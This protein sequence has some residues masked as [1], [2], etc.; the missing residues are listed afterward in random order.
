MSIAPARSG[1]GRP[2]DPDLES[3][4]FA[5][6]LD[7]YAEVGWARFSLDIVARRARVGKAALYS[8]WGSK[9]KLI[10][11]ALAQRYEDKPHPDVK[12][13]SVRSE[14]IIMARLILDDLLAPDSLVVLRAMVEARVYPEVFGR[15]MERMGRRRTEVGR[16]IVLRAIARG[17]LPQGTSPALI[18]DAVGG[19]LTNHVLSTPA[20]K[21]PALADTRDTYTERIVDFVL[22]GA[23]Y[24][25]IDIDSRTTAPAIAPPRGD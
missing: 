14:L 4:V 20:D 17:E 1:P 3:R 24:R 7:L 6:T 11:A 13:G 25:P 8:R 9:E 23:H 2:P 19:I 15:E 5:A 18:L 22:T 16:S 21:L 12:I 10:V